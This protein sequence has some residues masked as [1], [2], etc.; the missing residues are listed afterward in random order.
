MQITNTVLP[1]IESLFISELINPSERIWIISAWL[2]DFE[3]IN[4]R[5]KRFSHIDIHWPSGPIKLT[6]VIET[7][8]SKGSE[9]VCLTNDDPK[10]LDIET[11]LRILGER[12]PEKLKV[13]KRENLHYKGILTS[14]FYIDGSMN[15]THNGLNINEEKISYSCQ[16]SIIAENQIAHE[17]YYRDLL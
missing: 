7:L 15:F 10:N 4:N 5:G 16:K 1:F 17:N 3:V 2:T 8:L 11:R 12:H 14:N 6:S 9:I 13:A